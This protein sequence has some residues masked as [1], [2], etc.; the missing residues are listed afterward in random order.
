MDYQWIKDRQ[1]KAM[2][3]EERTKEAAMWRKA[4]E[5]NPK[6]ARLLWKR[7]RKAHQ[8]AIDEAFS[9]GTVNAGLAALLD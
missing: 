4:R 7:V 5:A 2:L 3:R 9:K 8:N 6:I 1:L